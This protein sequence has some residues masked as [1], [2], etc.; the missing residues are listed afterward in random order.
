MLTSNQS[1]KSYIGQTIRP[2]EERLGEHQQ[3]KSKCVA[4]SNAIQKHGWDNF[5]KD[6]YECPDDDLDKHEELMIEV[7][8]T[9][10]PDGYNLKEGGSNGKPSEES[11]QKIS[12]ALRGEKNPMYGK[13]GENNPNSGKTRSEETK[14]KMSDST[15]G[16]KNHMYG[17]TASEETKQ[18]MSESRFGKLLSAETKQKC[19][20][21]KVGEKNPMY[22]KTGKKHHNSKKVYQYDLKGNII[23]SFESG[24]EAARNLNKQSGS[25]I[26]MC[27]CGDRKS[28]YGFKWSYTKL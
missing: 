4:I 15:K 26:S 16:E 27:A 22:G 14:Q 7:L 3:K 8:G 21:T 10:S 25:K 23:G 28:A 20:E 9:L 18:K 11:K 2:I 12:E 24:E 19:R 5:E 17:K 1:G 13:I 6:W